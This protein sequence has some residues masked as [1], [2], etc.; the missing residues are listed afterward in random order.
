MRKISQHVVKYDIEHESDYL[1]AKATTISKIYHPV[2]Q[3][4]LQNI[5]PQ[6]RVH[7]FDNIK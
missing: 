4:H 7:G 3:I 6:N 1:L 2:Y 5:S